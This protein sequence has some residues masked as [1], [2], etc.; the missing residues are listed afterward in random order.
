MRANDP[1]AHL[2]SEWLTRARRDL[3]VSERLLMA[4]AFPSEAAFHVQQAAEKALKGLLTWHDVPFT[5]THDLDALLQQSATIA[6][7]VLTFRPAL[8]QLT[9]YAVETRYPGP[10]AEPT[11]DEARAALELARQLVQFVL[12]RLPPEVRP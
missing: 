6:P 9:R 5:R 8:A 11:P 12:A 10:A 2:T 7:D 3:T 4:P 1:R